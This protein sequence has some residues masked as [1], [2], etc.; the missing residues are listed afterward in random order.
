MHLL[1]DQYEKT[2][3]TTIH[4]SKQ[5]YCLSPTCLVEDEANQ[6]GLTSDS[7]RKLLPTV[8]EPTNSLQV[9][10][11]LEQYRYAYDNLAQRS[12]APAPPS[13]GQ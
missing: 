2:N 3:S 7:Q 6:R 10:T 12:R 4:H 11:S 1:Q 9:A 5:G 8:R 13:T